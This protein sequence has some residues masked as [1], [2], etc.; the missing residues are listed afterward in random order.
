MDKLRKA[1][2][3][4]RM[5]FVVLLTALSAGGFYYERL[6]G[7]LPSWQLVGLICAGYI[8]AF[9]VYRLTLNLVLKKLN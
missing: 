9:G 1:K 4:E 7:D 6:R 3:I 5:M 8:V 2:A